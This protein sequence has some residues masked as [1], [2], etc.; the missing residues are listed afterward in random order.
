MWHYSIVEHEQKGG[1]IERKRPTVHAAYA[2]GGCS[3]FGEFLVSFF[4]DLDLSISFLFCLVFFFPFLDDGLK[5][6]GNFQRA[7]KSKA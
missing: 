2:D 7:V 4:F 5:L 6:D 1:L 3:V